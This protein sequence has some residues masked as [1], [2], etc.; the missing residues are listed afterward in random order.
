MQTDDVLAFLDQHPDFLA[1]HA[2]RLG[3]KPSGAPQDR[4]VV[5]LAE[6]QMLDLKDRNRQLESRLQQ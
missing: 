6:R 2:E 1:H 5:S 3:L 4:V